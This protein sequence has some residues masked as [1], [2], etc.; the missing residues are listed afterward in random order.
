M[1]IFHFNPRH[2]MPVAA[3]YVPTPFVAYVARCVVHRTS[4]HRVR[5]RRNARLRSVR[6]RGAVHRL[7]MSRRA[8]QLRQQT[9]ALARTQPWLVA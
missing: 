2:G 1:H 8:Q 5:P 7:W 6:A 9:L 4:L 3:L